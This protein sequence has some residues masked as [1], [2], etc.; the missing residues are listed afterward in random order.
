MVESLDVLA[1]NF[2]YI[3]NSVGLQMSGMMQASYY[4]H[5]LGTLAKL[6]AQPCMRPENP[7]FTESLLAVSCEVRPRQIELGRILFI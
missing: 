6:H 4:R 5:I 2:L 7:A 1:T 3:I